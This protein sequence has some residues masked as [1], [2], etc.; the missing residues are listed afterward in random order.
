METKRTRR[1][2]EF[3][4]QELARI[5][6]T[7]VKDPHIQMLTITQ[8]SVTPDLS[9]ARVYL[10]IMG[11]EKQRATTLAALERANSFV[12][13]EVGQVLKTRIVPELR[14]IY[15]DTLDY[16]DSIEKLFRKIHEDD[17]SKSE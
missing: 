11:D 10:N 13:R 5:F 7:R 6:Q 1:V 9:L 3:M 15:D 12:R 4:K 14:F 2:G 17:N 8:V 16:A